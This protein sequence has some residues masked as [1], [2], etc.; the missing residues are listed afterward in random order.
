MFFASPCV[1]QPV[2]SHLWTLDNPHANHEHWLQSHFCMNV[3]TGIIADI[4]M[5][6]C[7]VHDRLTA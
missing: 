1:Q 6:A 2:H 7:L 4:V 5:G 3:W